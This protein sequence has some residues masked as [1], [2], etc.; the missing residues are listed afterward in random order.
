VL[1]GLTGFGSALVIVP[2]LAW[3]WPLLMLG[4]YVLAM[5]LRQM[6]GPDSTPKKLPSPA[7]VLADWR[8]I[9]GY[10]DRR[11]DGP[12]HAQNLVDTRHGLIAG[13]QWRESFEE[14]SC[15]LT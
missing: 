9:A 7:S 15:S 6:W 3:Q 2:R 8:S 1:L 4:L 5:G 13:H 14:I 11:S 12:Q 10:S